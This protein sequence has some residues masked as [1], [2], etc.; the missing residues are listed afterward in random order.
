[1]KYVE[2]NL[3]WIEEENNLVLRSFKKFYKFINKLI[4]KRVNCRELFKLKEHLQRS[5][6]WYFIVN[7][8]NKWIKNVQRLIGE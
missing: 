7:T 5:L 1:M 8:N 6:I 4:E 2:L 3:V